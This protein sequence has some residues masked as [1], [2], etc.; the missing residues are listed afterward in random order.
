M[1]EMQLDE[2][3]LKRADNDAVCYFTPTSTWQDRSRVDFR[4]AHK[5]ALSWHGQIYHLKE[6]IADYVKQYRED[7]EEIAALKT[8]LA[9]IL[10]RD[11]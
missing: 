2:E 10:Q 7:Q 4:E 3:A 8:Q 1:P 9:A 6:L 5:R 11:Q